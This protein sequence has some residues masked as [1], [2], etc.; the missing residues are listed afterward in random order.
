MGKSGFIYI[1]DGFVTHNCFQGIDGKITNA[2]PEGLTRAGK[3]GGSK[4][5]CIYGKGANMPFS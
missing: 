2:R 1:I 4:M 5:L 3:I